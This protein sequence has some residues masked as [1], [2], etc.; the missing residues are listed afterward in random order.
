MNI[1]RTD[2]P[3]VQVSVVWVLERCPHCTT[4][5]TTLNTKKMTFV[6]TILNGI[7]NIRENVK[8]P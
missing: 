5:H 8:Q 3:P 1:L 4:L 2:I 6:T 7:N